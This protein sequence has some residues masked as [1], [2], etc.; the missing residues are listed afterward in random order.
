[1]QKAQEQDLDPY[2]TLTNR[3][4]QVLHLASEGF[5]NTMIGERLTISSR[6]VETHRAKM[7]R[8]LN[9]N[10]QTDLI[11]YAIRKG[12]IPLEEE[13]TEFLSNN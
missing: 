5:S 3:E 10:N 7:M 6:T 13:N 9:L 12:I 4:R 8:K 1:L 11:R 2:D